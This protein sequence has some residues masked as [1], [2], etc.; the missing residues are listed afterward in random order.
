VPDI[1]FSRRFSMAHRLLAEP[2]SKC[3]VPH[4][5]N[6]FVHVTLRTDR[7]LEFGGSN[8]VAS[9]ERLKTRWHSFIDR[10]VDHAFQLNAA[11]PLLGWFL[12]NEPSRAARL[13][14]FD[15][16]PTSEALAIALRRK[17]DVILLDE[18]STFRCVGL[19]LEETP[20]NAVLVGE[21]LTTAEL[22]WMSGSWID[23]PDETINDLSVSG[24]PFGVS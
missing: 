9:F 18:A 10:A 16:D 12:D 11:D 20:T 24:R 23:R 17:L 21:T 1:R 22:G 7:D 5:H 19:T 4:G 6:E 8:Y 14:V 13:M 15:G 2:A 3:V